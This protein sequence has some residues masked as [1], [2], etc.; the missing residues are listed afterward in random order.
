MKTRAFVFVLIVVAP[1]RGHVTFIVF[2]FPLIRSFLRSKDPFE[3]DEKQAMIPLLND[4]FDNC[5]KVPAA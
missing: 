3:S 5:N 4:L 2:F 1:K